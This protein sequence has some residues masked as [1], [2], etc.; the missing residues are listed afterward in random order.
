MRTSPSP[1]LLVAFLVITRATTAGAQ[2]LDFVTIGAPGNRATV[3]TEVPNRPEWQAG[4]VGYEYRMMRTE[5]TVAQHFEFA[6]AYLQ[7]N[8]QAVHDPGLR[9][10]SLVRTATDELVMLPETAQCPSEMSWHMA[11]RLCNWYHNGKVSEAWAFERGAYDTIT[12]V[13]LP[14]GTRLDQLT[15]SPGARFWI[16]SIDEWIKAAYYD[17]NR[18]GPGLEGYWYYPNASNDVLISDY[19]QNGGQT[20][21]G[22]GVDRFQMNIG[23][24]PNVQSPWGLLDVSGGKIEHYEDA[25]P[26]RNRHFGGTNQG[27]STHFL[28]DRLDDVV[29]GTFAPDISVNGVRLASQVPSP[30]TVLV[31]AAALAGSIRRNRPVSTSRVCGHVSVAQSV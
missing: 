25:T 31:L 5:L 29:W 1:I 28:F 15:R 10:P 17:P 21:A 16:P 7:F 18:Y 23:Q 22:F 9:G 19:P 12:F 6:Q 24:Y 2:P 8:P 11:A 14:D 3:S 27:F 30:S 4:S 20:N 13:Q 26:N